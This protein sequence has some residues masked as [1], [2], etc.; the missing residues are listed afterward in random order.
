MIF[1]EY[2]E[3][4]YEYRVTVVG[5]ETFA[6][7]IDSQAA[8]GATAIDWRNYNLSSTPHQEVKLGDQLTD[9]LVHFVRELGLT[10]GAIDL[11]ESQDG[12]FYILEIN[13]MGQWL[14]IEELT[15]MP[16]AQAIANY[17]TS[18]MSL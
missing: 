10:Y 5:F 12:A 11:V 7:R 8:G 1:Q 17:L 15:G 16:I 6:C 18:P 3:K 2:I 4:R 9:Q 13:S 14:W